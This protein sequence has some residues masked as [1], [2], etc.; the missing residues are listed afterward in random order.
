MA[1]G[2]RGGGCHVTSPSANS[3]HPCKG[4]V[5]RKLVSLGSVQQFALWVWILHIEHGCFIAIIFQSKQISASIMSLNCVS[6]LP[7][8]LVQ[9]SIN[10]AP[11]HSILEILCDITRGTIYVFV[12][13]M[14]V[15]T[16]SARQELLF[17]RVW[18]ITNV[19]VS[20]MENDSKIVHLKWTSNVKFK[21]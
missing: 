1:D 19:L 17:W 20:D 4:K 5:T 10:F 9:F 18:G 7:L 13:V 15:T 3:T 16:P 8:L 2:R 21:W 6:S 12:W 14:L 11:K